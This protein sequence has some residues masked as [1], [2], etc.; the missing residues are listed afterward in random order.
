MSDDLVKRL[1]DNV[2][3]IIDWNGK[4]MTAWDTVRVMIAN[5]NKGSL[6]RDIMESYLFGY[7]EDMAEAADHIE[8]L[9]IEEKRSYRNLTHAMKNIEKLEA[10]LRFYAEPWKYT[11]YHGDDVQVP[12]FYSELD[13]GETARKALEGKDE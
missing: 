12:D 5:G 4:V 10:A 8:Q 7:A 13:F 6:P 11:D 9:E 2:A 3:D 1:R